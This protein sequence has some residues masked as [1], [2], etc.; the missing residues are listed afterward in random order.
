M[1]LKLFKRL[2]LKAEEQKSDY[3]NRHHILDSGFAVSEANLG[4][5]GCFCDIFKVYFQETILAL[6]TFQVHR[7]LNSIF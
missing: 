4:H 2:V 1:Y 3:F 7:N 5:L 6:C